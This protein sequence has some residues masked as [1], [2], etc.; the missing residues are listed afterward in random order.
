MGGGLPWPET[1]LEVLY[2][3]TEDGVLAASRL[4]VTPPA[5][6]AP[7]AA[8]RWYIVHKRK[9]YEVRQVAGAANVWEFST[10][11]TVDPRHVHRINYTNNAGL[12]LYDPF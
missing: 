10:F 4:R 6:A 7:A 11:D 8:P 1:R 12:H 9:A 2:S 5:A 3:L